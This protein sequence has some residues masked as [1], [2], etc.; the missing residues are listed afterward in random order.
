MQSSNEFKWN[1]TVTFIIFSTLLIGSI[2]Y[3]FNFNLS[4]LLNHQF[5]S[6]VE[7]EGKQIYQNI[8]QN[9]QELQDTGIALAHTSL[10]YDSLKIE[11]E[12]VEEVFKI[13]LASNQSIIYISYIKPSG[14]EMVR[15]WK[16]FSL[17][18]Q[19]GGEYSI[20]SFFEAEIAMD[21][22]N[23]S[24]NKNKG[25]PEQIGGKIWDLESNP[26]PFPNFSLIPSS[27]LDFSR[28]SNFPPPKIVV[29][30]GNLGATISIPIPKK[31]GTI[32]L[33]GVFTGIFDEIKGQYN[34]ILIDNTGTILSSNFINSPT[35]QDFLNYRL[36]KKILNQQQPGF[37]S[38]EIY[39]LPIGRYRLLL[40]QRKELLEQSDLA[41]KKFALLALLVA[42]FIS[43]P[44]GIFFSRPL[45]H[46][47]RELDRR[48][49]EE[50]EKRREKEQLLL[51]Q[52]KLAA[53]GEMLGNIAHQWR[54]PLTRLSLLIQNL[55]LAYQLNRLD[56][57]RFEQFQE[58]ALLQINYMS[59][60]IDDFINFFR[61]DG[62][63]KRFFP[64]QIIR[65]SL[66]LMEG[67]LKQKGVKVKIQ[68]WEERA[69]EGY[70][71]EFSQV[72]LNILNNAIDILT[73]RQIPNP[74]IWVRINGSRLEI[75]DN[76][77]GVPD[78][79]G[80]KIFEPYFT[81]KFQ[82]QGTGIGLYMSRVIINQHFAGELYYFNSSRG[83]TFVILIP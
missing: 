40:L 24:E 38:E 46:F 53:L 72:I 43:I 81:T 70:R 65:D 33:K 5:K 74:Q 41:A 11:P 15:C 14:Q 50:V 19:L 62:R 20:K 75:E 58:Q 60:T 13:A 23:S 29:E 39:L 79:I 27:L 8:A 73:E 37:V 3:I 28:T 54:H 35:I 78:E 64:S 25:I 34:L 30:K 2:T 52:S 12:V 48:V 80:D 71:S 18:C 56:Q 61:K 63:K 1:L 44:L 21:K 66:K 32:K 17:W 68:V 6:Q 67:R 55:E 36:V 76:G 4:A 22:R 10:L 69:I 82:S 7:R 83:A 49:K 77:G 9:L 47:Y 16:R 59:D 57:K 31:Q 51:H 26:P 42:I 45:L